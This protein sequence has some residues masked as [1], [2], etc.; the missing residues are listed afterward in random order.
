MG[1]PRI[2]LGPHTQ[3][4]AFEGLRSGANLFIPEKLARQ[5]KPAPPAPQPQ[6]EKAETLVARIRGGARKARDAAARAEKILE[7]AQPQPELE[8]APRAQSTPPAWSDR[9]PGRK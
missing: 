2:G 9:K 3:P 1:T 7:A 5:A 6:P 8:P 4:K